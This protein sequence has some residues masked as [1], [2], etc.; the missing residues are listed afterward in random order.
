[1]VAEPGHLNGLDN[2]SADKGVPLNK[3]CDEGGLGTGVFSLSSLKVREK[4][5]FKLFTLFG[6]P[7]T[8]PSRF[9]TTDVVL[10]GSSGGVIIILKS[11]CG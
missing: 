7:A 5:F 10:N 9:L 11:L 8:V 1:M 4:G 3:R 6:V 2:L